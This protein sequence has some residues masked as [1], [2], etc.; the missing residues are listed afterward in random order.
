MKLLGLISTVCF[1]V[2]Y[3]PQLIH[4]YR[5]RTV[6]GISTAYWIIV[7]A[8]YVTG[9]FYVVPMRDVFLILTYGVGLACASAML[10]GCLLFRKGKHA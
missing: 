9:C 2:S 4:T 8:G 10:I 6:Q 5:T 7:V 1:T 3:L